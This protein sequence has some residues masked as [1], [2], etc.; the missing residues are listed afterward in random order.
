MQRLFYLHCLPGALLGMQNQG[1]PLTSYLWHRSRVAIISFFSSHGEVDYL[2]WKVKNKCGFTGI[3]TVDKHEMYPPQTL[4]KPCSHD[5][6]W[7]QSYSLLQLCWAIFPSQTENSWATEIE[8]E[9]IRPSSPLP[10]GYNLNNTNEYK[11]EWINYHKYI[12][13]YIQILHLGVHVFWQIDINVTRD[14]SSVSHYVDVNRYMYITKFFYAQS[15]FVRLCL[16]V[17][18]FWWSSL[19]QTANLVLRSS[20]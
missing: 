11:H 17:F 4:Y 10:V 14:I 2:F 15:Y 20:T 19:F 1:P 8:N 5:Q 9:S 3:Q 18:V 16:G 6:L 7:T 13:M 12:H